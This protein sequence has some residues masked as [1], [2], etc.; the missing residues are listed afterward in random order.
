MQVVV[1]RHG[2]RD[3]ALCHER[4]FVGQGLELAPLTENGVSPGMAC[5]RACA[6]LCARARV[7]PLYERLDV[8][9]GHLMPSVK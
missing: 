1:I 6:L 5:C 7:G 4:G 2:E 3:D 9:L 8:S